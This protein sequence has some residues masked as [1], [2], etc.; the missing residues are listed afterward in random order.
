MTVDELINYLNKFDKHAV[1]YIAIKDASADI[2]EV[3]ET[4]NEHDENEI[5]IYGE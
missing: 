5:Q 2:I 4:P 3:V 1:V